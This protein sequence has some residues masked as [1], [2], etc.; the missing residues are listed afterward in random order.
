D[1]P[2]ATSGSCRGPLTSGHQLIGRRLLKPG[3]PGLHRLRRDS[4]TRLRGPRVPG[5]EPP[6]EL[7]RRHIEEVDLAGGSTLLRTHPEVLALL[8][9][10]ESEVQDDVR[11]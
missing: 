1:R 2:S 8:A 10:P 9:C 4:D 3:N 11:P 7:L 6:Q 5:G